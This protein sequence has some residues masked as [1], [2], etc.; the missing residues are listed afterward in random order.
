SLKHTRSVSRTL[1]YAY[2]DFCIAQVAKALG[3][4]Q[5]YRRYLE[6]SKNWMNL[7]DPETRSVRPRHPDGAWLEPFSPTHGYPDQQYNYWEAPFYEGNGWQYSTFVPHDV[8]TLIVLLGGDAPFVDWLD[9][10]FETGVYNHGNEPDILAPYLYIHAGRP[11]RT[12]ER[13]RHLLAS[14]YSL[15]RAGLPGNDDAGTLSSWYVWGAI[16]LYPS[17]GQPFYYLG[18]PLFSRIELTVGEGEMFI[19]EARGTSENN[20]YVQ[21]AELN[22]K[23]LARA[24]LL[25][26]EVAQ[27]GQL[28]LEMGAR[29]SQW[30]RD[31]ARG[32]LLGPDNLP[33]WP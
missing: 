27:G 20:K 29:P 1:E 5:D 31:M 15:G 4:L 18:S 3:K 26:E 25:H 32:H 9:A 2:N 8:R 33:T 21:S 11:D 22:G 16:G 10:F 30:G 28:V 7:W 14:E 24:W 12:A 19:I 17:A 23:P 13:V 6:R